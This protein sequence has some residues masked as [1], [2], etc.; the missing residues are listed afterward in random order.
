MQFTKEQLDFQYLNNFDL[1]DNH[2]V[3]QSSPVYN[4][5]EKI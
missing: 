3:G 5:I 1:L 4:R 2:V